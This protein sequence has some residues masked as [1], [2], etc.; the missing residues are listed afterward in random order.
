MAGRI[1][2]TPFYQRHPVYG[3]APIPGPPQARRSRADGTV[4]V[5]STVCFFV[6]CNRHWFNRVPGSILGIACLPFTHT[7]TLAVPIYP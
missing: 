6:L 3:P 4:T 7:L 2:F 1:Q 5:T